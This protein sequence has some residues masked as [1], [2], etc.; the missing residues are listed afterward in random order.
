MIAALAVAGLVAAACGDDD[1]TTATTTT[2]AEGAGGGGAAGTTVEV[3]AVDYAFEDLPDTVEAGTVLTLVNES[4][5]EVHELVALRLPDGED[6][7]VGQLLQLPEEELAFLGESEPAAVLVAPPGEGSI[8]VVGDGTLLEP[9]RYAIICA[10]PVGADPQEFLEAAQTGDG[11]P[12][13]AGGPPHF[14][15]G[16]WAELIVE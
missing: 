5:R 4:T 13:V 1:D 14:V 9:G 11:P 8:A 16:M 10:I 7:S 6:R 12:Q 3:T 15:E 2:V